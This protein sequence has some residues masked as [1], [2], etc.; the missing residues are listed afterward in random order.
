MRNDAADNKSSK[1]DFGTLVALEIPMLYRYGLFLVKNHAAAEDL[2]GA[3]ILRALEKKDQFRQGLSLK[4]WLR[5]I[6]Y[7]IAIDTARHSSHEISV[8]EVEDLWRDDS[9]S[10]DP[11][12]VA[13]QAEQVDV[14]RNALLHLPTR[15]S[16]VVVLHDGEG[17]TV[18][19]IAALLAITLP[20]AKQRLRRGRMMLVSSLAKVEERKVANKG[21]PV[22][23]WQARRQVSEYLDGALD[24][25]NGSLLEE[26]L[27]SCKTC[28]PLYQALVGV[29]DSLGSFNE[30]SHLRDQD[31]VI[32]EEIVT[33]IKNRVLPG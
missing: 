20:A 9:Y 29:K 2:V 26:H 7:H 32:P 12:V 25:I 3:T 1:D 6:L 27:A 14:L 17:L 21:V 15:Y 30:A 31:S 13:E 33:R 5:T 4:H 28:P 24:E 23:C 8:K 18:N 16:S 11:A 10:V 19:E 22:S